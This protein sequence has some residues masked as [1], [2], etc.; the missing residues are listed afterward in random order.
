MTT[1]MKRARQSQRERDYCGKVK[2]CKDKAQ[3]ATSIIQKTQDCGQ[4]NMPLSKSSSTK[5]QPGT[6]TC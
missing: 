1:W 6:M 4:L 3:H 2:V 5:V